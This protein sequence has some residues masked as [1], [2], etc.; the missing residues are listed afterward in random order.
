MLPTLKTSPT[1]FASPAA[2]LDYFE[3]R[4]E[5]RF[6]VPLRDLRVDERGRLAHAGALPI[7][8]LSKIPLTDAALDHLGGLVGM[9]LRYASRI[10]PALHEHSLNEL[11]PNH[12]ALVTVVVEYEH[13]LPETRRVA[14]VLRG[15]REGLDNAVF[16]RRMESAGVGAVVRV[17]RGRMDVRFGD[18]ATV[19]VLPDDAIQVSGAL[20]NDHWGEG[21][22]ATQPLL[23]VG[24]HLLRLICT[25]GAYA[26]RYL[27]KGRLMAWSSQQQLD[28]FVD[29]QLDRVL[30][31]PVDRVLAAVVRRM[32]EQMPDES[33]QAK[34]RRLI[35]RHVGKRRTA[36]L[37]EPAVSW[38]DHFNAVTAAAHHTESQGR[39]RA[40]QIAGG[41]LFDRFVAEELS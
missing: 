30:T 25:N 39:Q 32:S 24:L 8:Q 26:Q 28:E 10:D 37:L 12:L 2:A 3:K 36:E 40:L 20:R 38:Y 18:L 7:E 27:A 33:E 13:G 1:E 34:V 16:L 19:E 5:Q 11:M 29:R 31:F 41:E 23:D 14:A 22:T 35:L 4:I 15:A 9:P 21:R 17:H 6:T